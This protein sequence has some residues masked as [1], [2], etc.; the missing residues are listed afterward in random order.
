MFTDAEFTT[1]REKELVLKRWRTFLEH[2][3]QKQHFTKRLYEHLHLHC[4]FIAHY[5]LETFY[6]TYFETGQDTERLFENFCN[7]TAANYGTNGDYDDVNT[8]MRQVYEDFK[9]SILSNAQADI[10]HSLDVLDACVE[11]SRK[12]EKFA[13]QFLTKVRS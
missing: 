7:Y 9:A 8:A 6:S 3:L 12:D 5:N 1:A 11:R 2:G 4:G 13:R 10:T